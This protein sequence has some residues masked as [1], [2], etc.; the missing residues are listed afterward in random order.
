[1][2]CKQISQYGPEDGEQRNVD[3]EIAGQ[4]GEAELQVAYGVIWEVVFGELLERA[5][6]VLVGVREEAPVGRRRCPSHCEWRGSERR[7]VE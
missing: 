1:M 3:I 5:R 6:V 2:I 4:V 7:R